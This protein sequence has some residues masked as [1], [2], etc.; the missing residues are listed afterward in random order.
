MKILFLTNDL[1]TVGGIQAYN[2]NFI[3][4]LRE[5][6]EEVA[7]CELRSTSLM[8]KLSFVVRYFFEVISFCPR[9]VACVHI[10]FSPLCLLSS[11]FF[12]VPYTV[13]AYGIEI[14]H[15][16][17][18]ERKALLHA[19]RIVY[20]FE[21]TKKTV[22]K[23][24]PLLPERFFLLPNSIDVDRFPRKG[25]DAQLAGKLHL[26]GKKVLLTICRLSKSERDNKGYEKVLRALPL[27]VREVPETMYILAGSGD[28]E[29]YVKEIV[30]EVRM[31]EHVVLAGRLEDEQMADFYN[32]A[33]VFVFPSKREGFPAIVLLEA[34]ACGKPIVG[35][36]QPGSEAFQNVFG[37]IV[38]PDDR[39]ALAG[40]MVKLLKREVP[41]EICD[42]ETLRKKID[43]KY[44]MGVY[45]RRIEA[46]LELFKK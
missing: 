13:A 44:G 22:E 5:M 1:A 12:R 43:E 19:H 35:G 26:D 4:A 38:D 10:A 21:S 46:Y 7:T 2:K 40:A 20:L 28:D 33:D 36:D 24:V 23:K 41:A 11:F 45:R 32:L 17:F 37:L 6:G 14:E 30:K 3:A 34:L 39:A 42:P 29:A 27:V 16:S 25:R 8:G 31:G 18:W 15:P 9:V